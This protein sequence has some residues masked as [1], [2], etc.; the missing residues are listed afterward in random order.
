[1]LRLFHDPLVGFDALEPAFL[2]ELSLRS[3]PLAGTFDTHDGEFYMPP[4]N[5]GGA[6][7]ANAGPVKIGLISYTMSDQSVAVRGAANTAIKSVVERRG[8]G[9]FPHLT[10]T[11][12]AYCAHPLGGARMAASKDRGCLA[13][14]NAADA[15]AGC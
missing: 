10:E 13:R 1:M 14:K 4:P 12:G 9:R 6:A 8:L 11:H 2:A 5:G 7:D 3:L 15:P